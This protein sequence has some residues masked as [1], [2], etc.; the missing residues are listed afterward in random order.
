MNNIILCGFK[1]SGKTMLGKAY[2]GKYAIP[3][4]DTDDLIS[5]KYHQE[6]S[7]LEPTDVI[8]RA[9]G[10]EKFRELESQVIEELA[11]DQK[12]IIAIGG[13][14]LANDK[15]VEKLKKLG[16]LVYLY[17]SPEILYERILTQGTLPGYIDPQEPK[18]SFAEYYTFLAERFD[19]F[20]DVK[21]NT[22]GK[23]IAECVGL[24]KE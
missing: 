13:G 17:A 20:S 16:K 7:M 8:F 1:N 3:F 24:I 12:S 14:A 6:S 2:S 10:N 23:T 15:S 9:V 22:G 21:I 4:V 11:L 19:V 18:K 5:T